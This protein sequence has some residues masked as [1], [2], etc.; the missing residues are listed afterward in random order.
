MD[1]PSGRPMDLDGSEVQTTGA[2]GKV[3]EGVSGGQGWTLQHQNA[4]AHTYILYMFNVMTHASASVH[5]MAKHLFESIYLYYI[6]KNM[7]VLHIH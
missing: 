7:F 4:Q 1:L 5:S 2:G 3:G 6:L